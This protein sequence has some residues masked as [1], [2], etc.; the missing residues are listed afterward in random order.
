MPLTPKAK[1]VGTGFSYSTTPEGYY[2]DDLK[3]ASQIYQFLK[4]L[5]V[6]KSAQKMRKSL[7]VI[8]K[9][10]KKK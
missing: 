1:T 6:W 10:K 8:E 7:G 5:Y 2:M 4:K 9:K 3:S